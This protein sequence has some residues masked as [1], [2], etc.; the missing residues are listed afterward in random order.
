MPNRDVISKWADALESGKYKQTVGSLHRVEEGVHGEPAGYCCLG[1]LCDLAVEE[2]IIP[3]PRRRG[4]INWYG[5]DHDV[6]DIHLP[7][8]VMYW[9]GLPGPTPMAKHTVP[10]WDEDNMEE[11]EELLTVMNDEA[12][13]KFPQIAQVIR[14]N[15][16]ADAQPSVAA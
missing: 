7:Y 10:K 6:S 2:G 12:E 11:V 5:E 15:Y 13:M 3:A 14:D 16:L 4:S 9:A 1:V 8:K